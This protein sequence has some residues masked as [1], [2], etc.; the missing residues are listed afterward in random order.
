MADEF[1][2]KVALVTGAAS[3]IGRAT[4]RLFARRGASVVAAD[5]RVEEGQQVVDLIKQS[6]GDATFI[7]CDVSSALD[8]EAMVG[9][10]VS[11]SIDRECW[12][13]CLQQCGCRMQNGSHR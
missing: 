12:R 2:G 10:A 9:Q 5:V 4:A 7:R 11:H 6:G 13:H 1:A 8:V 3:G